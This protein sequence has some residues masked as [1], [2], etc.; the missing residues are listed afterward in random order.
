VKRP[1]LP[2]VLLASLVIPVLA[3]ESSQGQ[4]MDHSKMDH[5]SMMAGKAPRETGQSAF[6][7][8]QEI[9]AKLEADPMTDWS[10]V[11]IE[12]LRQHLID[13]NNVTLRSV[14][15]VKD[16]EG[17][18]EFTVTSPDTEVLASIRRMIMSHVT[19]MNG[20]NGTTMLA[21]EVE[22]GASVTVTG[23]AARI[24]ALGFIGMMTSGMH[25][26]AHHWMIA[27]GE[28]PHQP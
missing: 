25:H 11:N 4:V 9:V 16:I 3:Q 6:A 8:I 10:K 5:A 19:T 24:R 22:K 7:A 12:A 23:D 21:H 1:F 17:G 18:A 28:N 27:T 26:Q 13:M 15:T 14:V 2:V 20:V